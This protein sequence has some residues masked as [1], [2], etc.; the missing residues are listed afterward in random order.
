MLIESNS[1]DNLANPLADCAQVQFGTVRGAPAV[2]RD[3]CLNRPTEAPGAG[4][5]RAERSRRR[6]RAAAAGGWSSRLF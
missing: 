1:L 2:N 3:V 5:R 6:Y 4:S